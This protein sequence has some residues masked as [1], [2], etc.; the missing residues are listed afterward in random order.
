M[1]T[2]SPFNSNKFE[3]SI[4]PNGES[5]FSVNFQKK[6]QKFGTSIMAQLHTQ[7]SYIQREK[8]D[9]SLDSRMLKSQIIGEYSQ[10]L[11]ARYGQLA[12][13]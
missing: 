9:T 12:S 4:S 10:N 7:N 2:L 13:P 1:K 6:S 3:R 11:E 8:L 5:N